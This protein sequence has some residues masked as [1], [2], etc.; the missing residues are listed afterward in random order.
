VRDRVGTQLLHRPAAVSGQRARGARDA[1]AAALHM[2]P[3]MDEREARAPAPREGDPHAHLMR[4]ALTADE[5]RKLRAWAA[6][7]AMSVQEIVIRILRQE[8]TRRP[9]TT[10]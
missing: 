3:V 6:E 4:L 10:Y 5:W 9:G 7:D 2:L 1:G 8:L